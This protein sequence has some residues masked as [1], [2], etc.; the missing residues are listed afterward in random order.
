MLLQNT[1]KIFEYI[2]QKFL[3][4]LEKKGIRTV[5]QFLCADPVEVA[6]YSEDTSAEKVTLKTIISLRKYFFT[7]HAV[8]AAGS[9]YCNN[10]ITN[11]TLETDVK[12]L[13]M[14]LSGGFKGGVIYE[15]Y[16]SPGS[17]RTQLT[18][19]T[20][21]KNAMKGGNTL[22]IDTKN[23]FC[24]DR[25][26]EIISSNFKSIKPP[27]KRI[28]PNCDENE[29]L[30]EGYLNKVRVA[31]VFQIETLLNTTSEVANIMNNLVGENDM[32]AENWKFYRN[33]R[34]LVLDNVA[35]IVLPLLGNDSYPMSD[36]AALTSQLIENLR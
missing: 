14:T 23:D 7:Q 36:I 11:N 12:N 26:C 6:K 22:Y 10:Q 13:D 18:L 2:N 27:V 20:T 24:I 32:L 1:E 3:T 4:V 21:A 25:F 34:L 9:W 8:S 33:V 29:E 19:H 15:I 5:S 16:G 35:S 17:G 28:K 31:K 30:I